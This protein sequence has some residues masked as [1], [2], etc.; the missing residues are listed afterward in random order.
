MN[1]VEKYK[2]Y[3]NTS[4]VEK[5][6]PVVIEKAAGAKITDI[7]GKSYIDCFSGIA[8]V[9]AGHCNEKVNEAAK[10]QI[11]KLRHYAGPKARGGLL[12]P[13][14]GGAVVHP[15]LVNERDVDVAAGDPCLVAR[16]LSQPG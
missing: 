10:A 6:Q 16:A 15:C 4:M 9:N 12:E 8:V 5:V 3:V 1:T 11:D 2:K 14:E 13:L 7:Q